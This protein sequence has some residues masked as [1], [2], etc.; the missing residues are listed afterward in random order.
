M[1]LFIRNKWLTLRGSS[2]V[3]DEHEQDILKVQGKF[4]TFTSKKFVK[5]LQG[6]VLYIV[7]NKFWYLFHRQA[8]VFEPDGKTELAHLSKKIFTLHDHYNIT[9]RDHG[10]VVVRG[11]ILGYDY[12]IFEDGKEIGHVS[13]MISLRDSFTLDI[14][15]SADWKFYCAIVIAIDNILDKQ[16]SDASS[17]SYYYNN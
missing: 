4:F 11:N 16:R 5:D 9:T 13:R 15:D 10:E 14:D 7:R 3:R 6:N 1:R 2:Y 17:S 12:H 8:F